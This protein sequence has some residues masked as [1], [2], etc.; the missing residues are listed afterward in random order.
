MNSIAEHLPVSRATK[1][2][3]A[4]KAAHDGAVALPRRT[5]SVTAP[6]FQRATFRINGTKPLVVCRFSEEAK[7]G[8]S[9]TQSEGTV[10]GSRRKRKKVS[11]QQQFEKARYYAQKGGWEGFQAS[12][13][14]NAMISACRLTDIK[15]TVAKLTI[16]CEEDGW[17]KFEPQIPLVRI[18]GKPV[19][20]T[21]HVRNRNSGQFSVCTR[22][23]YPQWAADVTIKWDADRLALQD[24]ANLLARVGAQ[25][26]FGCGRPDSKDSAGMGWGLFDVARQ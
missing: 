8:I 9:D 18:I 6:N 16:F 23:A 2:V 19:L 3:K 21:D 13:V 12:A 25:V 10:A 15:M 7:Q 22:A 1:A 14:R 26:G 17:D 5:V 20:Q 24:I 4:R 11:P